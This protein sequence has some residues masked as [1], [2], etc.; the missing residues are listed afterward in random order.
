MNLNECLNIA[1]ITEKSGEK[2][3]ETLIRHS[4]IF[5]QILQIRKNGIILIENYTKLFKKDIDN[6]SLEQI[7]SI[8][9]L[10]ASNKFEAIIF[11]LNFE[12]EL[13]KTYE[14]LSDECE[15]ESLKDIFFRLWAT[16]NNEYIVA[17]KEE[18][19]LE[20]EQKHTS[21]LE[22]NMQNL[23]S[24]NVDFLSKYQTNFNEISSNLNN[25]ISGKADKSEITKLL[26][27]PNFPFFGGLA[28]GALATQI[29]SKQP[30]EQ[31]D[32]KQSNQ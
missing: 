32:E 13:N 21:T 12:I 3:Y 22:Q 25:I 10:E 28:I 6:T 27:N 23:S 1:Y 14:N 11:A 17:L 31:E 24:F 26:A 15:D 9:K 29:L 20:L 16:S 4:E 8:K 19:R 5:N 30:K 18:L 7:L 2:L